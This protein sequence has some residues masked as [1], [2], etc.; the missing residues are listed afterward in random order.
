MFV[1]GN[2]K[3]AA[4]LDCLNVEHRISPIENLSVFNTIIQRPSP[5]TLPITIDSR[6][7]EDYLLCVCDA[8]LDWILNKE[9]S[10]FAI[11]VTDC[12]HLLSYLKEGFKVTGYSKSLNNITK[13]REN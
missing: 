4:C 7:R 8:Q 10:E 11:R 2:R 6:T 9:K 13:L 12:R 3:A 5:A 1:I